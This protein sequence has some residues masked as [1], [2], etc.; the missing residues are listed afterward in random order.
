[1]NRGWWLFALALAVA[2][3]RGEDADR[4]TYQSPYS[5]KFTFK[6]EELIGDLLKGRRA[7]WKEHANVPFH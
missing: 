5:V 2:P 4:A 1:M 7:D 6:E 3:L